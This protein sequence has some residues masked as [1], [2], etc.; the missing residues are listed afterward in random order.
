MSYKKMYSYSTVVFGIILFILIIIGMLIPVILFPK[1]VWFLIIPIFIFLLLGWYSIGVGLIYPI[2]ISNSGIKYRGIKYEWDNI[3]ITA[4]SIPNRGYIGSYLLFFGENYFNLKD[5]K[6]ERKRGFYLYLKEKPL[7]EILKYYKYKILIL[8]FS[9]I[10]D[11][12]NS[13]RKINNI[14]NE[15]NINH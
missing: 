7:I 12:I 9:G 10:E 11:R 5:I 3:K 8:D 13:T 14:I 1:E 4:Y 6:A 15:H 2:Y